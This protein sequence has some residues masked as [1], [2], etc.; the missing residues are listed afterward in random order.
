MFTNKSRILVKVY[1]SEEEKTAIKQYANS[2]NKTA[3]ALLRDL[4]LTQAGYVQSTS[5]L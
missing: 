1:M 2:I 4:A 3:S 5:T